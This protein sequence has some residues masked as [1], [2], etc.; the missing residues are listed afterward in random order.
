MCRKVVLFTFMWVIVLQAIIFPAVLVEKHS[1]SEA[2][3]KIELEFGF[4]HGLK[5][6]YYE[7]GNLKAEKRYKCGLLE[8]S[9]RLFYENGKMMTEW[10][11]KGGK[12]Q[13]LALGYY[14]RGKLKDKGFYREGKLEGPVFK[15]YSDGQLKMKMFFKN[16]RPD[17]LTKVFGSNGVLQTEY[18]YWRGTLTRQKS[19]DGYGGVILDQ[20]FHR[21]MPP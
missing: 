21:F 20:I 14:K 15:Y 10:V 2:C 16:N 12:R 11:Y 19:Y 9:S 5:K 13:G 3:S 4:P 1:E 7:N 6:E 17:G 8:G 18:T